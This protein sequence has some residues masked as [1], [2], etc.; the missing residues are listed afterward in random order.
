MVLLWGLIGFMVVQGAFTLFRHWRPGCLDPFFGQKLALLRDQLAT[1]PNRPLVLF[2]GSSRTIFGIQPEILSTC[3]A[4]DG[5]P[6]VVFNFGEIGTGPLYHLLYL[7]RLLARG[8]RPQCL[9]IE[10]WSCHLSEGCEQVE[11]ER[12][13]A[14]PLEWSDVRVLGHFGARPPSEYRRWFEEQLGP[15]HTYRH[16]LLE[17]WAVNWLPRDAPRASQV[18]VDRCGWHE[19]PVLPEGPRKDHLIQDD[20]RPRLQAGFRV[21]KFSNLEDRA[22]RELLALCRRSGIQAALVYLPEGRDFQSWCPPTVWSTVESYLSR[23]SQETAVPWIDTRDWAPDTDLNDSFH[24]HR[25]GAA[26]F[27]ERFG[28]EVLQPLLEG[29]LVGPGT[30]PAVPVYRPAPSALKG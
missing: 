11:Q 26:A 16:A 23:L 30:S 24:L 5:Q 8:I 9:F 20:F 1:H 17:H 28:R 12:I 15:W 21:W 7:E 14:Q 22:L 27:S 18:S 2:L 13:A 29:R 25:D 19:E 4:T 6:P 3:R 10:V